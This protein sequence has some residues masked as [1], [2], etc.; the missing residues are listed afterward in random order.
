[1]LSK[2]TLPKASLPSGVGSSSETQILPCLGGTERFD[3]THASLVA[4]YSINSFVETRPAPPEALVTI[5]LYTCTYSF[6]ARAISYI[7]SCI[8]LCYQQ[9]VNLGYANGMSRLINIFYYKLS[10][11]AGTIGRFCKHENC[12][13]IG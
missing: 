4:S 10:Y 12:T 2:V 3:I 8:K 13:K 6:A 5:F 11:L 1:M 7:Q 9:A